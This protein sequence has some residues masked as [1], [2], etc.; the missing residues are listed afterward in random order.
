M[1]VLLM[2]Q[3]LSQFVSVSVFEFVVDSLLSV[4]AYCVNFEIDGSQNL[5]EYVSV[6][7]GLKKLKKELLKA[8]VLINESKSLNQNL[9]QN[10][11]KALIAYLRRTMY[12]VDLISI[13]ITNSL[14]HVYTPKITSS[15]NLQLQYQQESRQ[16][17]DTYM[18]FLY[19][20]FHIEDDIS[21]RILEIYGLVRNLINFVLHFLLTFFYYCEKI[22]VGIYWSWGFFEIEF[23]YY[24]VA[25]IIYIINLLIIQNWCLKI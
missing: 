2:C 12:T 9:S 8:V 18:I 23:I 21:V 11:M 25:V 4:F 16:L 5:Y 10:A 6:D 14:T 22:L 3:L 13:S 7:N 1:N 20:F 24:L 17:H 19:Q 15:H